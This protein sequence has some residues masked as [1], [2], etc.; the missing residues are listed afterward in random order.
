M[1]N[2]LSNF[3]DKIIALQKRITNYFLKYLDKK[4]ELFP[5]AL[6]KIDKLKDNEEWAQ[7]L[8]DLICLRYNRVINEKGGYVAGKN[9]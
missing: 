3:D 6:K 8:D 4:F 9:N 2:D 7:E 5:H 1:T